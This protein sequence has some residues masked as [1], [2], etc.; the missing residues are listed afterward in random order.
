MILLVIIKINHI[1]L[2]KQFNYNNQTKS[3]PDKNLFLKG[4]W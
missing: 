3:N 4:A 1:W 2:M